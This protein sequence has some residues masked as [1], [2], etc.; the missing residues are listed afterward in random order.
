MSD[1][2]IDE[3][4]KDLDEALDLQPSA[5]VAARARTRIERLEGRARVKR[6]LTVAAALAV[7]TAGYGIWQRLD[8]VPPDSPRQALGPSALP[9]LATEE[10][11][12][13]SANTVSLQP[14]LTT[15]LPDVHEPRDVAAAGSGRA[16]PTEPVVLVGP[17]V[18]LALEQLREAAHSNRLTVHTLALTEPWPVTPTAIEVE[19]L[20]IEVVQLGLPLPVPGP[21]GLGESE[22]GFELR[23]PGGPLRRTRS[24]S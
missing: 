21:S 3:L 13:L 10:A 16:N 4:L 2:R 14:H 6:R 1:E 18:R 22:S 8:S 15:H 12:G 23:W 11:P 19:P 24:A 17:D 5:S 7:V 20:S 9:H